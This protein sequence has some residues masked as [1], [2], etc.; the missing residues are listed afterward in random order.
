[1]FKDVLLIDNH[2]NDRTVEIAKSCGARV[3]TK[4]ENKGFA[5]SCIVGMRES[6]KI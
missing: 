2:S 3:I 6:L 4:Y 5:H 1:M